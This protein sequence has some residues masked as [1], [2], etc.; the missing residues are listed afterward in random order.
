MVI[1]SISNLC[2]LSSTICAVEACA[3][4]AD[5]KGNAEGSGILVSLSDSFLM[6]S[7]AHVSSIGLW[8]ASF[9]T[10]TR[11]LAT[12]RVIVQYVVL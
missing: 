12:V 7:L 4:F 11:N 1:T 9:G 2:D 3:E 5:G 6:P 8:L 10:N